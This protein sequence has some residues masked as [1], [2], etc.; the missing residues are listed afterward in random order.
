M[1]WLVGGLDLDRRPMM[2]PFSSTSTGSIDREFAL[3]LSHSRCALVHSPGSRTR[4][5][6]AVHPGLFGCRTASRSPKARVSLPGRT[7]VAR[8]WKVARSSRSPPRAP[9]PRAT[10]ALEER[11][12]RSSTAR[13]VPA[14]TVRSA[15]SS[16]AVVPDQPVRSWDRSWDRSQPLEVTV[17]SAAATAPSVALAS[18]EAAAAAKT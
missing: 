11:L 2:R 14:A 13:R 9:A 4:S 18:R 7:P 3:T 12:P 15:M 6:I 17:A 8:C 5:S 16:L 10:S 1:Q